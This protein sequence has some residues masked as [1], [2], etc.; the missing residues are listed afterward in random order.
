MQYAYALIV[1]DITAVFSDASSF[2]PAT[3]TDMSIWCFQNNNKDSINIYMNASK[4]CV[5]GIEKINPI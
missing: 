1:T 4:E 5:I 3:L 2:V